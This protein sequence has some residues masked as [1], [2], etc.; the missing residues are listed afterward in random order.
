MNNFTGEIIKYAV[1]KLIFDKRKFSNILSIII[2]TEFRLSMPITITIQ[3]CYYTDH[4]TNQT[5]MY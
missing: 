4:E 2:D 5:A 1:K 3:Q